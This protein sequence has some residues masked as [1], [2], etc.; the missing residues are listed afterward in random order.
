MPAPGIA[1]LT[2]S[3]RTDIETEKYY[4]QIEDVMREKRGQNRKFSSLQLKV[5]MCDVKVIPETKRGR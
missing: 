3:M 2:S 4:K 1:F 5:V